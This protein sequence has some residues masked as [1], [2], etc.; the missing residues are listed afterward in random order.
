MR[1]GPEPA[2]CGPLR[3]RTEADSRVDLDRD[4]RQVHG[5][6]YPNKQRIS[7]PIF[8]TTGAGEDARQVAVTGIFLPR[9]L[10]ASSLAT[11]EALRAALNMELRRRQQEAAARAARV[12]ALV[13]EMVAEANRLGAT[14]D[15]IAWL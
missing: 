2:T 15:A 5:Y 8:Q 13:A 6:G 9:T 4:C 12:V 11:G 3:C 10:V 1:S 7:A 14:A